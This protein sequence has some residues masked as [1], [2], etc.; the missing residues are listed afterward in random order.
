M[1]HVSCI[2]AV[3]MKTPTEIIRSANAEGRKALFEHE[4]KDLVRA[5]G[6]AVPRFAL[7]D[8]HD[9]KS[10]FAV[11]KRLGFPLA[12]KAVSPEV[13]HKTEAGAVALDL[14]NYDDLI[15]AADIM[16]KTVSERAPGAV[17]RHF[18]L[19]EMM[20]PGLELLIGGLR[21]V[22]FGPAV[23]FG[24]GGIWVEALKDTA[25]GIVPMTRQETIDMM[26]E[27]RAGMLLKGFRGSPPLDREAVLSIINAVSKL[28][29]DFSEI[30]EIDLNPVRVYPD[31]AAALDVRVLLR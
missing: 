4:A 20:A 29:T 28:M 22:Q 31:G 12:L 2:V 1:D 5:V 26:D 3:P 8:T 30:R 18:L 25:F 27:T 11:A 19:E 13:L 10:L 16:R 15:D 9:K 7:V 24:L 23:A 17:I 21:D 14:A 6:I